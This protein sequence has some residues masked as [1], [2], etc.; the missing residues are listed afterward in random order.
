MGGGGGLNELS[1]AMG[2]GG[3]RGGPELRHVYAFDETDYVSRNNSA[4]ARPL[5]IT[6]TK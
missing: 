1:I 5:S 4:T 6:R 3:V 2:V